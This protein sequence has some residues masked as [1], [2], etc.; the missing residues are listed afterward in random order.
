MSVSKSEAT[1]IQNLFAPLALGQVGSYDLRDDVA[2]LAPTAHGL[3][4]TQDQIIE[5]T[6]FLPDDPLDMIARRLVR[7][8]LSDMIAKGA[9]PTAAFLSLA[10]P[11]SRNRAGMTEFARGLGEDLDIL[12]GK[13]PLMG[14][15]TSETSG[16]L[17]AS[18]TMI[19]RPTA[20]SGQPVLRRGAQLGDVLAV[21]GVIGD[22]WLGL[23]ARL[24][25]L[26]VSDLQTCMSFSL[27]PCP[28]NVAIATFIGHYARASIDVSDG[29][30]LDASQLARESDVAITIELDKIPL[31]LEG[32]QFC[33]SGS[34]AERILALAIGGDDYQPL[35]AFDVAGFKAFSVAAAT[36]G[37]RVTHIG[38]CTEGKGV[39]LRLGG[40]HIEMP[41]TTGW[42]I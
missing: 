15:D 18:L 34:K 33:A 19:G 11:K 35:M 21:T 3:V 30:I 20:S 22:S 37:V 27:A 6:H 39:S 16:H 26:P 25:L 14:G 29:L 4:V 8:N 24:G 17:V 9:V 28:P 2:F 41:S 38:N 1:L 36:L 10:W 32:A 12:C 40:A 23:Q 13:C 31:S 42:Q 7:R 5:N